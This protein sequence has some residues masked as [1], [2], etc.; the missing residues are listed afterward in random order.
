MEKLND[1]WNRLKEKIDEIR[2]WNNECEN[3]MIEKMKEKEMKKE[4][5]VKK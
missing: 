5:R 1:S 3:E 2:K 4:E